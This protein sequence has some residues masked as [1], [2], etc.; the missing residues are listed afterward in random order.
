MTSFFPIA[1]C[2]ISNRSTELVTKSAVFNLNSNLVILQ[3]FEV[4]LTHRHFMECGSL[5]PLFKAFWERFS[6]SYYAECL[7]ATE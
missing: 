1:E 6:K 7:F 3:R 2:G 5:L 4:S